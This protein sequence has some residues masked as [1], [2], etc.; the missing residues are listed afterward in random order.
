M[1]KFVKYLGDFDVVLVE[2]PSGAGKTL[3]VLDIMREKAKEGKKSF[4]LT[5]VPIDLIKE[6]INKF[7]PD[8]KEYLGKTIFFGHIEPENEE[9]FIDDVEYVLKNFSPDVI[10]LD[11]LYPDFDPYLL[12]ELMDLFRHVRK[13]LIICSYK[14]PDYERLSDVVVEIK[15]E[16]IGDKI[17]REIYVKKKREDEKIFS[18]VIENDSIFIE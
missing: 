3:L 6:Q 13:E 15:M 4:Y 11:P 8:S 1:S 12:K 7:Y 5:H 2:G 17:K 18:L 9:E 16:K 10:I 14:D